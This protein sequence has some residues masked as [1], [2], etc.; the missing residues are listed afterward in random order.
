M[1]MMAFTYG[2]LRCSI[3]VSIGVVIKFYSGSTN[4]DSKL[5]FNSK[6]QSVVS[7]DSVKTVITNNIA[8]A[9]NQLG[10]TLT[11][12]TQDSQNNPTSSPIKSD[13]NSIASSYTL[14][15]FIILNLISMLHLV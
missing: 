11:S 14:F 4:V 6:S 3:K 10:L 9:Q 15:L 8:S 1:V 5:T 7:F 2:M 13:G 12:I